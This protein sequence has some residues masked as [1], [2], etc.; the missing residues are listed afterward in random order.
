MQGI[1]YTVFRSDPILIFHWRWKSNNLL[2]FYPVV[3]ISPTMKSCKISRQHLRQPLL[4][5]SGDFTDNLWSLV[6]SCKFILGRVVLFMSVFSN[7]Y[8]KLLAQGR[9]GLSPELRFTWNK[10][11]KTCSVC[12]CQILSTLPNFLQTGFLLLRGSL[13]KMQLLSI[14]MSSTLFH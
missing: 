5:E 1:L 12:F 10:E 14:I 6:L 4:K 3:P 8:S 9:N 7:E 11:S 13:L 2:L